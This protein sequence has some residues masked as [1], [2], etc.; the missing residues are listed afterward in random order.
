MEGRRLRRMAGF[1]AARLPELDLDAVEDPR[2]REGKW[3]LAQILRATLLGLM[4]GCRSL[5]ETE[6]LTASPSV[7]S[8][9]QLGLQR[10]LPDTTARD[11]L[12][13]VSLDEVRA[14]LHRAVKEARRR[15]AL[16]PDGLPMIRTA[17][18][19]IPSL[20]APRRLLLEERG[21]LLGLVRDRGERL[22]VGVVAVVHPARLADALVDPPFRGEPVGARIPLVIGRASRASGAAPASA[23]RRDRSRLVLRLLRLLRRGS[24]CGHD[25][26]SGRRRRARPRRPRRRSG[27]GLAH[28]P[29]GIRDDHDRREAHVEHGAVARA[30]RRELLRDR[31][32]GGPADGATGERRGDREGDEVA[33]GWIL[34]GSRSRCSHG[35]CESASADPRRPKEGGGPVLLHEEDAV[36][37]EGVEVDVEVERPAEPLDRGDTPGPRIVRS[38]P[39]RGARC[40]GVARAPPESGTVGGQG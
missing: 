26:A 6:R 18:G 39:S 22:D 14:T 11:L 7:A 30:V 28:A 8:R 27:P 4:A 16:E 9:R 15:K 25:G 5:R 1:L 31:H 3:S 20:V 37:D 2:A 23:D 29:A 36:G 35:G 21:G 12:C 33:H 13:A 40:P 34:C 32:L 38:E 19:R 10:R 24:G 17:S